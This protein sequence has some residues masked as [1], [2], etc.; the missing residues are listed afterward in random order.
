MSASIVVCVLLAICICT[1]HLVLGIWL[2][3][4]LAE[5]EQK[6]LPDIEQLTAQLRTRL[7]DVTSLAHQARALSA[8]CSSAQ[9]KLPASIVLQAASVADGSAALQNSMESMTHLLPPRSEQPQLPGSQPPEQAASQRPDDRRFDATPKARFR[10]EAWQQVAPLNGGELP[11]PSQFEAVQCRDLSREGFSFFTGE[12]PAAETLVVAM[13]SPPNLRFFTAR[14]VSSPP[15][16]RQG[17]VGYQIECEFVSKLDRAYEWDQQQG[18]IIASSAGRQSKGGR[19][20]P[21]RPAQ[22]SAPQCNA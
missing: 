5:K 14:V 22:P 16:S 20:E 6:D 1:I 21:L 4:L 18:R 10:Y 9:P 17:K 13:G 2:G 7:V 8:E 3:R 15:A 11:D 19:N 12:L